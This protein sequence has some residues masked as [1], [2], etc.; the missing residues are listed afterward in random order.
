[1]HPKAFR[2]L[3]DQIRSDIQSSAGKE[4]SNCVVQE[5]WSTGGSDARLAHDIQGRIKR[6]N[7]RPPTNTAPRARRG[8][9]SGRIRQRSRRSGVWHEDWMQT[10]CVSVQMAGKYHLPAADGA[11]PQW[12]DHKFGPRD[13]RPGIPMA[14]RG[15]H[16]RRLEAQAHTAPKRQQP[17]SIM[18][19]EDG[20]E[21]IV[22]SGRTPQSTRAP[23]KRQEG[24]PDHAPAHPR[25][26]QQDLGHPVSLVR[27][28]KRM[29]I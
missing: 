11:E 3:R 28:Q 27:I 15:A 24:M 7:T 9:D 5:K 14:G 18:G 2:G 21:A 17:V 16:C 8:G 10:H 25:S 13:G 26:T 19:G 29:E 6:A 1:M 23:D 20:V 4:A 12:Q 22:T